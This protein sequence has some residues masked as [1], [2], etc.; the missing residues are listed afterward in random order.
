MDNEARPRHFFHQVEED[1]TLLAKRE[2]KIKKINGNG[3]NRLVDFLRPWWVGIGEATCLMILFGLTCWLLLPFM[4]E[5]D[6][7]NFFSAP[8][9]PV[10]AKLLTP[11]VSYSYSVRIWLII[12]QIFLPFS[13]Y[14]F[15]R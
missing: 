11:F 5:A 7:A 6:Q 8:V 14:L 9:I 2:E 13:L 15:V 4:G 10:L 3:K 1:K 12:F